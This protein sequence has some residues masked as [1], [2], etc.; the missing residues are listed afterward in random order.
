MGKKRGFFFFLYELSV[1]ERI[2][3]CQKDRHLEVL[4]PR[5]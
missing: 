4:L 5:G 1:D 2:L 3:E